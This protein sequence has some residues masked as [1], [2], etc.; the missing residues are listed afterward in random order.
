MSDVQAAQVV[1]GVR[2][3]TWLL[4][5]ILGVQLVQSWWMW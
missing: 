2:A 3:I 1:R 4:G 5:A